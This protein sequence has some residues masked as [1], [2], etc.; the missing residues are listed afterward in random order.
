M[1]SRSLQQF[2]LL[3]ALTTMLGAS[4]G[5]NELSA[6]D[7]VPE[8]IAAMTN[9]VEL[10]ESELRYYARQFK[11]KCALCHG[12]DGAAKGAFADAMATAQLVPPVDFTDAAYMSTRSDGQLFYQ[13][14][15]GGAQMSAMPAY[16]PESDYAWTEEKIWHVVAFVRRFARTTEP[17]TE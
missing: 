9:P 15:M 6:R 17:P 14:L 8:E 16:G 12:Q 3:T 10:E 4:L 7:D 13:I 11:G 5:L 2:T 1:S